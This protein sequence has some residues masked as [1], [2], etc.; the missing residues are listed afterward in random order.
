[1]LDDAEVEG[2]SSNESNTIRGN[3]L[4]EDTG[5]HGWSIDDSIQ[6]DRLLHERF[7]DEL[8]GASKQAWSHLGFRP[9]RGPLTQRD[10]E[11]DFLKKLKLT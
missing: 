6:I 9:F 3:S 4:R 5:N 7:P 10:E 1:M 8:P 2:W 11:L